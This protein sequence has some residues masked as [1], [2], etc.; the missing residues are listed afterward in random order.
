MADD[1]G[2][3]EQS[4]GLPTELIL[5]YLA[6]ARQA[7]KKRIV[8]ETT[9]FVVVT[10]L[11]IA[12]AVFLPRTYHAESRLMAQRSDVL[13]TRGDSIGDALRGA[14]DVVLAREN[15]EKIVKQLNLVNIWEA[16][17][18]PLLRA[19]DVVMSKLRGP[20]SLK[21]KTDAL[22]GLMKD[23]LV[24]TIGNGDGTL[25][26]GAD[27]ADP[28]SAAKI[29][30]AA[31]QNFLESR[32]SAEISMIA[33]YAAILE[34]HA[35]DARKDVDTLA[36]QVRKARKERVAKVSE[37][38]AKPGKDKDDGDSALSTPR[39]VPQARPVHPSA[40]GDEEMS[41]LKTQIET[42]RR[43]IAELEDTRRRSLQE[44]QQKLTDLLTKYTEAYPAVADAKSKILALQQEAPQ[45]AVLRSEVNDLEQE[46][47]RVTAGAQAKDGVG[48]STLL[49]SGGLRPSERSEATLPPEITD[50]LRDRDLI[51]PALAEQ[52]ES[53]LRKYRA[54]RDQISSAQIDVDTAQLAFKHRYKIVAPAEAPTKPI[55]PKIPVII[56]GGL[57]AG[58]LLAISAAIGAEL[59][60]DRIQ[61]R[62]QVQQLALPGLADLRFPP[63]PSE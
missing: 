62:W 3:E 4:A 29:V 59:R 18:P 7:L 23:K 46:L 47:K 42:K 52:F 44:Q 16:R 6:F 24:V 41:Q 22:V 57:V 8:L 2:D 15:L 54:L 10:A 38:L 55:K 21:D 50:L 39:Y 12:L 31:E 35:I 25:T 49:H 60:T 5:S 36:E 19:K 11:T 28:Q 48:T 34:D 30:E 13:A 33:D 27:W 26:I 14:P 9:I 58:L 56:I 43:S 63:G 40:G 61:Q 32:H 37:A 17:R 53:A 20:L 51:D 45:V 1:D